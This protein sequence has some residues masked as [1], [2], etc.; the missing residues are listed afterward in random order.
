MVTWVADYRI[1]EKCSPLSIGE[2]EF[3]TAVWRKRQM[4]HSSG[5]FGVRGLAAVVN[6]H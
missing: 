2:S 1:L 3:V 4:M 5:N 6:T